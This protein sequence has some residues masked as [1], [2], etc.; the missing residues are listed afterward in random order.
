MDMSEIELAKKSSEER[1]KIELLQKLFS[2]TEDGT[3]LFSKC[4]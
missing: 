4:D 3:G 2:N 1:K